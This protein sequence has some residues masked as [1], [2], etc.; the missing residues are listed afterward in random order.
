[1]EE[2]RKDSAMK[3]VIQDSETKQY[4]KKDGKWTP[5]ALEAEKFIEPREAS[6]F[7][8]GTTT[9]DFNVVIFFPSAKAA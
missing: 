3:V 7:A 4:L 6:T 1:V 5:Q 8:K 9:G 2:A